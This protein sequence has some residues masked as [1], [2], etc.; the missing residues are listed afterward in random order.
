MPQN[1]K[2]T[3]QRK[4][5]GTLRSAS[6]KT[7]ARGESSRDKWSQGHTYHN[8]PWSAS[9]FKLGHG[10]KCLAHS[11][12]TTSTCYFLPIHITIKKTEQTQQ[13]KR[14]KQTGTLTA[15]SP[16]IPMRPLPS[17]TQARSS[18]TQPPKPP[19][20]YERTQTPYRS[21]SPSP[22][23]ALRPSCWPM[24]RSLSLSGRGVHRGPVRAQRFSG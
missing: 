22:R 13:S 5:F 19:A 24:A 20:P 15:D 1:E 21:G 14:R 10:P 18:Q 2:V 6:V 9:R 4:V 12:C 16:T 17:S 23:R 11:G 7:K 8:W 3:P